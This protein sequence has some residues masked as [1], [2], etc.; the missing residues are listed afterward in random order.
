M[1]EWIDFEKK[2]EEY[3]IFTIDNK[4]K[5]NIVLFGNCHV[6]P[7]GYFLNYLL[8]NKYNIYIIISWYCDK[9]GFENFDM[10]KVN[11]KILNILQENCDI[12]LYQQHIK[13]Y[14]VNASI[15]EKLPNTKAI[16]YKLPN[17]R[18]VFTT[19]DKKEYDRSL[20]ILSYNI[21]YS[22]FSN[23]D[24]IVNNIKTIRFFNTP[25]HPTHYILYLLSKDIVNK[26]NNNNKKI[27]IEDYYNQYNRGDFKKIK[28]F[29]SLPGFDE[30]TSTNSKITS[31]SI[32]ADYFNYIQL[33]EPYTNN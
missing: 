16:I 5:Q 3:P 28:E 27:T 8:D 1:I 23:F 6:A 22:D 26:I 24:F 15:I 20:E 31:I 19:L 11:N 7:I 33:N 9:V 30:I 18:L 14:G 32:D 4:S 13:D 21:E 10:T 29:I 17:L 25:E 12:F 2:M